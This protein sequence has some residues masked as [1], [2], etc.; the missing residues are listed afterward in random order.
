MTPLVAS[1][2]SQKRNAGHSLQNQLQELLQLLSPGKVYESVTVLRTP[3][4]IVVSPL[5][6]WP[7]HDG[8]LIARIYP[9]TGLRRAAEAYEACIGL[10]LDPL[11]FIDA[12]VDKRVDTREANAL[13]TPCPATEANIEAI[14]EGRKREGELLV[15]L[16]KPIHLTIQLHRPSAYTRATGCTIEL[17]IAATRAAYW[18]RKTPPHCRKAASYY[19]AVIQALRCVE[20][21]APEDRKLTH[22]LQRIV[23]HVR[24]QVETHGCPVPE[25]GNA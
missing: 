11:V 2:Y 14:I 7:R 1:K 18:A 17:L 10:T 16:M 8:T 22:S 6:I 5:G 4:G 13:S 19:A 3:L 15:L 24:K 21:T 20:H 9:G 12:L 25:D 23:Q